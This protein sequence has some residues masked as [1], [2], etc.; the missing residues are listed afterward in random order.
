[1]T[2]IGVEGDVPE[3]EGGHGRDRPVETGD[4]RVFPGF[5]LPHEV[6]EE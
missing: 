4:E 3:A 6:A 5:E 2:G 1:M